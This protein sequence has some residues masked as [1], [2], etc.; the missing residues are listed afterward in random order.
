[1]CNIEHWEVCL[2]ELVVQQLG[3]AVEEAPICGCGA[4]EAPW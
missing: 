2:L 1:M 4:G 3:G